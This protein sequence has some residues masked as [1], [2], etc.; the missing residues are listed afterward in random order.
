[1]NEKQFGIMP[2]NKLFFKLSTPGMIAMFF[3][4]IG[5]MID[6]IFVGQFIGSEALAAVNLI[7]PIAGILFAAFDMIAVGSQVKI[8]IRLGEQNIKGANAMFSACILI[9]VLIGIIIMILGLLFADDVIY[10]FISDATLA[11]L[12]YDY[13]KVFIYFIPLLV[14]FFAVDNYLK[15]CGKA[16]LSMILSIGTAIS[17]IILDAILIG[18]LRLGI[19]YAAIATVAGQVLAVIIALVPFALKKYTL[20][21]TRPK[22]TLKE[23]W[24]IIFNG[25]SEFFSTISGSI[26]AILINALLLSLGGTVA[27]ASYAIIMY[28]DGMLIS[29][30]YGIQ[31]AIAPAVSYNLGAK[32]HDRI[33]KLFRLNCIVAFA[34]SMLYMSIM[35]VFPD[36]LVGIFSGE[37]E[38]LVR[39]SSK[40]ALLLYAPSYL[41]TW[42]IMVSSAFLTG[43]DKPRESVVI[44]LLK[45]IVF[46]I[47]S[48]F[49]MTNIIG[50]DGVYVTPAISGALTF[51][52]AFIIWKKTSAKLSIK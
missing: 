4:S 22:I 19:E 47:F 7:M 14:L 2:I 33:F 31:D 3:A 29:M 6:G 48:L 8:G 27:V 23:I 10:A 26:M 36:F 25:S 46:P 52:I 20:R 12:A 50:V 1:M 15:L 24:G 42:F 44:T 45:A 35:L 40:N 17:N 34:V 39:E 49:V 51:I 11:T 21:F 16:Q 9:M 30:L 32:L 5:M 18:Y 13:V 38:I 43:I 28:I 41:F 37:E